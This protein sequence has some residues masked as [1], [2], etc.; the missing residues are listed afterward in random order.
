MIR[1]LSSL[2]TLALATLSGIGCTGLDFERQERVF[3]FPPGQSEVKALLVY[4]GLR[5]TGSKPD[6]LKTAENQLTELF[7]NRQEFWLGDSA[8]SFRFTLRVPDANQDGRLPVLLRK[9]VTIDRVEFFTSKQGRLCAVQSLTV[10]EPKQLLAAANTYLSAELTEKAR[11]A[12]A[13]PVAQDAPN[14]HR[15]SWQLI[16]AACRGKLEWL[17]LE[18]G[19]FSIT[20]PATPRQSQQLKAELLGLKDLTGLEDRARL[21]A[22]AN[23]PFPVADKLAGICAILGDFCDMPWSLDQRPDRL[24]ISIGYGDGLPIRMSPRRRAPRPPGDLDKQ[25]FAFARKLE[26]P[27]V[28]NQDVDALVEQFMKVRK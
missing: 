27:L 25:L 11:A 13:N 3:L 24:V 17:H 12:L 20:I 14:F 1:S 2:A 15:E 23:V 18:P 26:V 7:V 8:A 16:A 19:R 28:E 22:K 6:D 9:H 4:E 10:R 21:A 5:L